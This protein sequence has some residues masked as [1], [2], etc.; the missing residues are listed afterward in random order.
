MRH[1]PNLV[2]SNLWPK[3]IQAVNGLETSLT[4]AR[5]RALIQMATGSGKT[6]TAITSIYRLLRY[7]KADRVL[8]LVDRSNLGR[9]AL[10]EFQQYDTPD[11]GRKFTELYNVHLLSSAGVDPAAKVV[12]CT[13]QRLYSMLKGQPL[14]DEAEEAS[15]F[16]DAGS[17]LFQPPSP[18]EYSAEY[19]PEF[20]DFIFID[21]CH[22][23]IY[24]LWRQVLEY[25]DAFLVGLTATPDKRAFAFFNQNLVVEYNHEMAVADRVNVDFDVY[26][27]RTKITE[28]GAKLDA[29][30]AEVGRRS[31]ATRRVRWEQLEDDLTYSGSQLDREVVAVDQIRTVVQAFKD[32]LFTDM[33]PG[34]RDVP[35]TLIFAKDDSH[36][37]DIVKAVREVF[38]E[39]NDFCQKITYRTSTARIVELQ[40]QADGTTKEVLTFKSSGLKAEDLLSS[41]RNSYYP[42]V[43][44]TVDMIATGTDVKPLEIVMF[45]RM[46]KS[47][48]YFEQMKGRGVRVCNATEMQQATPD[49][50]GEKSRFVIV[51]GVGVCEHDKSDTVPLESHRHVSFEKL[52]EAVSFGSTDEQVLSSLASRLLRLDKKLEPLERESLAEAAGAPIAQI[53]A[54][55]L[56]AL[57]PDT[58]EQALRLELPPGQ[59]PTAQQ[60]AAKARELITAAVKPLASNPRLREQLVITK[61]QADQVID[62]MSSDEVLEAGASDLS[63]TKARELVQ[64]F[65]AFIEQHRDELT[66]LRIL[67]SR[68]HPARLHFKDIK[69]LVA[70]I[71][72]PPHGWDIPRLWHAWEVLERDRVRGVGSKR[73]LTDLVQLVRF[74]L[75]QDN[76]LIPFNEHVRGRFDEWLAAQQNAGRG[77][78]EE[79]RQWL[80]LIRDYVA[81]SAE[82]TPDSFE[83]PPLVQHGGYGRA[84]QVFGDEL[85]KLLEELS[86]ALVA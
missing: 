40:E 49:A 30:F 85:P 81:S 77:F 82:I 74:T 80:T 35:K 55:I 6:F 36:A 52:L 64:D 62:A 45:M 11:D 83:L 37:D 69:A 34:R 73:L 70:A 53:A 42:R 68:P 24:S 26:R 84:R 75:E 8:F 56:H 29:G 32:A 9:Q 21:E 65:R 41:F 58:Q 2:A 76:V 33:F 3:Q 67:Y 51:D 4:L 28:Q 57:D 48:T 5:P 39:G 59:E 13:I 61:Q 15:A 63:R 10:K 72:A 44:V 47:R 43:V 14:D 23:S 7:G 19:P 18:V 17:A 22:R 78:T 25:F 66:A 46:V 54:D 16:E 86:E 12:I 1:F 38:D 50:G 31:R 79:Q 71:H 27:I 20:F 60:L